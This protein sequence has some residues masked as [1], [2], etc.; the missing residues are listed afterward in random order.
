MDED[1]PPDPHRQQLWDSYYN[2]TLTEAAMTPSPAAEPS[3]CYSRAVS[4]RDSGVLSREL[5]GRSDHVEQLL[6]ANR[7]L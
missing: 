6:E 1:M 4:R 7:F 5:T 2:T 3:L